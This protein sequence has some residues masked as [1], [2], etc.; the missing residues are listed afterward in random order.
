LV[1][2]AD[3]VVLDLWLE[4]DAVLW[5]TTALELLQSYIR[6]GHPVLVLTASEE[7]AWDVC[8]ADVQLPPGHRTAGKW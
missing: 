6:S 3:A 1:H 5:G 4:S 2:G 8:E 7:A